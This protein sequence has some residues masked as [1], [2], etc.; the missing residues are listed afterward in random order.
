M[1]TDRKIDS[2]TGVPNAQ[3]RNTLEEHRAEAPLARLAGRIEDADHRAILATGRNHP[4]IV[5]TK[6]A[7]AVR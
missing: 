2:D 5:S 3:T 4:T 1:N 6:E 7:T